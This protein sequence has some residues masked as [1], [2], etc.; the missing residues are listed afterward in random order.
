MWLCAVLMQL[1]QGALTIARRLYFAVDRRIVVDQSEVV[2]RELQA[3]V[4]REAELGDLLRMHSMSDGLVVSVLRGQ[5]VIEQ[6]AIISDPSSFAITVCTPPDLLLSR[7]LAFVRS[8][9][10]RSALSSRISLLT[11]F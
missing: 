11:A 6:E 9:T 2:A 5:R 7:L 4:Q 8:K 3:K 10:A 1:S